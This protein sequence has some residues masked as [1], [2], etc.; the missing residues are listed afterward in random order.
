MYLSFPKILAPHSEAERFKK[1][2]DTAKNNEG[3]VQH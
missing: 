3:I 2:M 1:R